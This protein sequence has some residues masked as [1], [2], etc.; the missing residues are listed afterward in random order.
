MANYDAL[1]QYCRG[2]LAEAL[3][4]AEKGEP[5]GSGGPRWMKKGRGSRSKAKTAASFSSQPPGGDPLLWR[6]R[7]RDSVHCSGLCGGVTVAARNRRMHRLAPTI[8]SHDK[9]SGR[10]VFLGPHRCHEEL[11]GCPSLCSAALC[12]SSVPHGHNML[13]A[14]PGITHL[15]IKPRSRKRTLPCL[16]PF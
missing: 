8:M 16:M 6:E 1:G 14:A 5:S 10:S 13:A 2:V 9:R 7:P 15:Y 3:G 4:K 12:V 11:R